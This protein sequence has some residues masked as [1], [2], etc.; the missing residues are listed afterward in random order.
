MGVN[1]VPTP[2]DEEVEEEEE[3]AVTRS[4][5]DTTMRWP[6]LVT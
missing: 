2:S 6:K 4:E 5:S 1:E 3:E